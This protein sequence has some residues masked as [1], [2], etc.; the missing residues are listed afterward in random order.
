MGITKFCI[1]PEEW[2]RSKTRIGG[3]KQI[4]HEVIAELQPDLIIA[5]KEENTKE[6]VEKLMLDYPVWVSDIYTLED[7][8][9]MMTSIGQ[10]TG[11]V[12]KAKALVDEIKDGFDALKAG[13]SK[14]VLYLIWQKPWMAAGTDNFIQE[15]LERCGLEN[16][17][18]DPRYPQL[19]DEDIRALNPEVVMLSSEPFPFKEKHIQD[20]QSLLPTAKVMLVDGELF[21]W[22]GSRLRYSV[23]YLEA[24]VHTVERT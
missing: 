22:Y 11:T 10:I 18:T 12:P 20:I 7:A 5:N 1:H 4:K 3:T 2:F 14:R 24:L 16:V 15:M 17:V 23:A 19:S 8:L 6:D 9:D 13:V 21:S